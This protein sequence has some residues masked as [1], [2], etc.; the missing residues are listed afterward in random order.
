MFKRVG[1]V[2]ISVVMLCVFVGQAGAVSFQ[3]SKL[4]RMPAANVQ[5]EIQ[6][7]QGS[8]MISEWEKIGFS[9]DAASCIKELK[10]YHIAAVVPTP[11]GKCKLWLDGKFG[12]VYDQIRHA[13]KGAYNPREIRFSPDGKR[14]AYTARKD[15][16]WVVIVDGKESVPYDSVREPYFS[17]DGKHIFY[18]AYCNN[19]SVVVIDGKESP[20]YHGVETHFPYVISR[21]PYRWIRD[22][23]C[24]VVF[25]DNGRTG[26]IVTK[27]RNAAGSDQEFAVI[28]GKPGSVFDKLK[29]ME[30]SRDGSHIAYTAVKNGKEF[31]VFDGKPG[32]KY[33]SIDDICFSPDGKRFAYIATRYDANSD[34]HKVVVV[35]GKESPKHQ[36]IMEASLVF[37]KDSKHLTYTASDSEEHYFVV[38]DG[39]PGKIYDE[40]GGANG[41]VYATFGP[42]NQLAYRATRGEKRMMVID[43]VP[44]PAFEEVDDYPVWS[45]DGTHYAYGARDNDRGFV[46]C[47]GKN[48]RAY[49]PIGYQCIA[50][51]ADGKVVYNASKPDS[52]SYMTVIDGE[53][54][55][56]VS[57]TVVNKDGKHLASVCKDETDPLNDIRVVLEGS[58]SGRF[59]EVLSLNFRD[60]G[61]LEFLA[62]RDET[63]GSNTLNFQLYRVVAE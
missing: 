19:K 40:I 39:K 51:T 31:I 7:K 12:P 36:E 2:L 56:E 59:H 28:D 13:V 34:P 9:I 18:V 20:A 24:P 52:D 45:L 10:E 63:R 60:D 57:G 37:S 1:S 43:S 54:L 50:F 32:P 11:D 23:Y 15:G 42:H 46:V 5:D 25:S 29:L 47:D 33:D 17:F 16:K 26:Y 49:G 30:F 6:L 21:Y 58:K 38:L 35:D 62:V 27:G 48:G 61:K 22:T 3:E 44:S 41:D 53:E 14:L 55:P 8:Q 4:G